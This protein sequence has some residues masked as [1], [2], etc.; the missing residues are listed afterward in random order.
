MNHMNVMNNVCEKLEKD[1]IKQKVLLKKLQDSN[2]LS[3]D[4]DNDNLYKE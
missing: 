4:F 2:I 1:P 3:C